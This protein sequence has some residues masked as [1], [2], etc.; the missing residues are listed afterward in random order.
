M[1]SCTTNKKCEAT[2]VD[3]KYIQ[4]IVHDR[5]YMVEF[6]LDNS[7]YFLVT[8]YFKSFVISFISR[9]RAGN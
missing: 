9:I 8:W 7:I 3:E 2:P 6:F 1:K 4:E 5:Y